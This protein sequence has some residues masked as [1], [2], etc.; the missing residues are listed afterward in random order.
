MKTDRLGFKFVASTL[1][2]GS[3]QICCCQIH[4][5]SS[6]RVQL[7][8]IFM[9]TTV[10]KKIRW[11]MGSQKVWFSVPTQ[12]IYYIW[13]LALPNRLCFLKGFRLDSTTS[14]RWRRMLTAWWAQ[15]LFQGSLWRLSDLWK[16]RRAKSQTFPT[17]KYRIPV[18]LT[19]SGLL[20]DKLI[21]L[22]KITILIG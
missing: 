6:L 3:S 17:K 16:K 14:T 5:M 4:T 10:V 7:R 15:M 9:S 13:S 21:W 2:Q 12:I 1:W 20:S 22:W 8:L 18:T 19:R 11:D